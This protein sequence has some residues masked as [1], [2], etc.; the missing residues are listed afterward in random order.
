M[1]SDIFTCSRANE[2]FSCAYTTVTNNLFEID[3]LIQV[4]AN[5]STGGVVAIGQITVNGAT[6]PVQSMCVGG[7]S[8]PASTTVNLTADTALSVTA[9]WG[10]ASALNTLNGM[11]YLI[12]A[13]N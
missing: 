4:R 13:L 9:Q 5:G 12:E 2:R 8:A 1:S 7:A 6:V 10:T 11:N 3:I